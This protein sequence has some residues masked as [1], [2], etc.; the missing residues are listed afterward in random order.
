MSC[1]ETVVYLLEAEGAHHLDQ[2]DD[3]G[4]DRRR[5]VGVHAA[6]QFALL[7][8][9]RRRGGRASAGPRAARAG[10]RG[11]VSGR[12]A[13]APARSPP[14]RSACPATAIPAWADGAPGG[15][16]LDQD[17][18]VGGER[19]QLDRGRRVEDRWRSVWRTTPACSDVCHSISR[20]SPTI[21]SVEP[22]PMS[23]TRVG[24]RG[25]VL[26]GRA[27]VGEASAPPR[28]RGP[29]PRARS[30]RAARRRRRPRWRRRG[31]RWSRSRRPLSAPR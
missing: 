10:G 23:I 6:D 7:R 12:R 21:S 13:R 11:R 31:R 14:A 25:R 2:G 19:F 9:G 20:P 5:P 17:A 28:R 18:Q 30:A 24:T 8:A 16:R 4:D 15:R 27:E 26:G 22:P 3:A 29:A 1:S